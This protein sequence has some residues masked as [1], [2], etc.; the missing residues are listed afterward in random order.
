M[1]PESDAILIFRFSE[2][3][4]IKSF[5]DGNLN[6]SCAG[7]YIH[8]AKNTDNDIQGD[9]KEAVFARLKTG[10]SKIEDYKGLLGNDLELIPDGDFVLLRRKSAKLKPIFCFYRYLVKD[11]NEEG[12]FKKEGYADVTHVFDE[13]IFSGFS[14][15]AGRINGLNEDRQPTSVAIRVKPFTDRVKFA[16]A[17]NGYGHEMHSVNYELFKNETFEVPL[18]DKYDEL[19]YKFPKYEYQHEGRILLKDMKLEHFYD[20]L[21]I[22]IKEFDEDDYRMAQEPFEFTVRV[23]V[24]RIK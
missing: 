19:F 3:R 4:W 6:F 11:A 15:T 10:D 24:G 13:R 16:M 17:A 9:E 20:R 7:N 22:K 21:N 5:I 23:K 2:Y 18:T 8:Q 1:L 12:N 14:G